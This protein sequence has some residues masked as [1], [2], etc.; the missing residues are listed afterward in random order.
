VETIA[1][2]EETSLAKAE[3][4]AAPLEEESYGAK[5]HQRCPR[6]PGLDVGLDEWENPDIAG[7]LM[8]T[9]RGY[10]ASSGLKVE[11]L[12]AVSPAAVIPYVVEGP[13]DIGVSHEPEVVLAKENGAPI[14][15]LGSLISRPTAAMIWLQKSKI[16]GIAD[17]KGK[18]VAIPG[19]PFQERFLKKVLAQGG[20]TLGD[21]KI[22]SVRDELVPELVSGNV[23]A[24]L[25][26]WNLQ[27]AELE[28]RGLKPVITRLQD[29]GIPTYD[30]LVLVARTDCVSEKPRMF[31]RFMSALARGTAAAAKD[32]N[33]VGPAVRAGDESYSAGGKKEMRL[34][35]KATLPLLSSARF[36]PAR[37]RR[38]IDWMHAEGMIQRKVP[39]AALFT[40]AYSKTS[41]P[42]G[43]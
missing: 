43:H 31:R 13:D 32:P 5:A 41:Q 23:D 7:I 8:A 33:G 3:E 1:A 40:N 26:H 10:F 38:L 29:L 36:S 34:K 39:V 9:E 27:G 20:L 14:V 22:K 18:T 24:I 30:E 4:T 12:V 37:A 17:L 19:L 28:A 42:P 25:G 16:G 11:P 6:T 15:I 35:V 21:V 2:K